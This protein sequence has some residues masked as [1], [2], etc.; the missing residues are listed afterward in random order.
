MD[1]EGKFHTAQVDLNYTLYYPL[2]RKY[3]ALF[4]AKGD[5]GNDEENQEIDPARATK[6]EAMWSRV[7][8]A[9]AD[10]QGALQALRDEWVSPQPNNGAQNQKIRK[11][12]SSSAAV[13][14]TKQRGVDAKSAKGKVLEDQAE[15]EDDDD[16]FFDE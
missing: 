14:S 2:T 5:A 3:C 11:G 10:G 6:D 8:Q 13:P 16:G 12:S 1:S 4:P 15:G 9:T 7:E